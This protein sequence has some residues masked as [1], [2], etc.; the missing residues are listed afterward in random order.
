[1]QPQ[2]VLVRLRNEVKDSHH[3]SMIRPRLVSSF[4]GLFGDGR[5]RDLTRGHRLHYRDQRMGDQQVIDEFA[6]TTEDTGEALLL[7]DERREVP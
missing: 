5:Y 4:D 3:R 6:S 1:M 2:A 7:R